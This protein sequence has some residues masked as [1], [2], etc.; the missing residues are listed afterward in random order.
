G[1]GDRSIGADGAVVD[2]QLNDI[3]ARKIG[4]ESGV[5]DRV[6][7]ENGPAAGGN[8]NERP[9][10]RQLRAGGAGG[11]A[12]VEL[13]DG[14][15][16]HKLLRACISNGRLVRSC[17]RECNRSLLRTRKNGYGARA[18]SGRSVNGNE[19]AGGG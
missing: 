14:A 8:R 6:I 10:V 19:C 7:R 11:T 13:N 1:D 3:V 5:N 16:L 15:G 17:D 4:L 18:R 12:A 9:L 2:H